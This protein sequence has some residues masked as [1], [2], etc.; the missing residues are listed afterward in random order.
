[1]THSTRLRALA[2]SVV[3]VAGLG[4]LGACGDGG[5]TTVTGKDGKVKV[6]GDKVTV[7]TSEGTATVGQGLPAD[8][9]EDQV[10]L[11]DEKV[12]TAVKGAPGGSVAWSV[13]MTS[14]RSIDDLSA[15]VEKDYAGAGYKPEQS[16]VM[17]DVSIHRFTN[18][19]Y[20]VSVT[21]A[22]TGD[23]ITITYLVKN[24]R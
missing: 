18:G 11:V 5:G 14:S 21:I 2:A 23:G 7:E 12:V 1:M 3:L 15:E 8:F 16:T 13:A 22:R 17:G 24:Q 6:D 19:T 9:P 10:P 20:D 4:T